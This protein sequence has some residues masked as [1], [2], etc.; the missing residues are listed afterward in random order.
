MLFEFEPD[1]KL[2]VEDFENYNWVEKTLEEFLEPYGYL[3]GLFVN[4]VLN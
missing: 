4:I 2:Y 3:L 1:A